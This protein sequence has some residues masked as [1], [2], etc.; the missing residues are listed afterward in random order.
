MTRWIGELPRRSVQAAFLHDGE[1]RLDIIQPVHSHSA[2]LR[3]GLSAFASI[4]LQASRLYV[5]RWHDEKR[6][7]YERHGP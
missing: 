6:M 5:R 3:E 4:V 7:S 1:E 2:V